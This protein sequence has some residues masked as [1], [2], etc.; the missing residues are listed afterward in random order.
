MKAVFLDRDGTINIE[1]YPYLTAITQL[2]I[3]EVSFEAIQL[4]NQHLFKTIVV[5]NQSCVG[6]G[7]IGEDELHRIHETLTVKLAEKKAFL[8]SIYYCPHHPDAKCFCRK[9]NTGMLKRAAKEHKVDFQKSFLVGD[10]LFDIHTGKNV[11]CKTILVLTGAGK[12]T[13]S[14]LK[15]HH[16]EPDYIA[17]DILDAARWIIQQPL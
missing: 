7:L 5:T 10:R 4:L 6:R 16:E 13:L 9:P 15:D 14:S 1:I 12:E 11:G 3:M 8:D 17:R 2:E